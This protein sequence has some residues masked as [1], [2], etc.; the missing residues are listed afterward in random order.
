MPTGSN[1][2]TNG[3]V[4][5]HNG[6]VL[7][8]NGLAQVKISTSGFRPGFAFAESGFA[9]VSPSPSRVSRVSPALTLP[10]SALTLPSKSSRGLPSRSARAI[11]VPCPSAAPPRRAS[12]RG[13]RC[14]SR[15]GRARCRNPPSGES[16][17]LPTRNRHAIRPRDCGGLP[18]RSPSGRASR[19]PKTHARWSG[20]RAR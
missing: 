10:A 2:G 1:W 5:G 17:R 12:R 20:G 3:P 6:L 14:V 8:H 7:G 15:R 4:L 13:L 11:A 19:R 9:R 18:F 16:P